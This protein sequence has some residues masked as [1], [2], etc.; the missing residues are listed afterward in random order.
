[1]LQIFM[2]C[3]FHVRRDAYA[4]RALNGTGSFRGPMNNRDII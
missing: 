1:M 3:G 2:L 4:L